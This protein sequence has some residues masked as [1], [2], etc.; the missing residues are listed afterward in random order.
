MIKK[1]QLGHRFA[2]FT[3]KSGE[4]TLTDLDT[5]QR[6]DIPLLQIWGD[7]DGVFVLSEGANYTFKKSKSGHC[8]IL[9]RIVLIKTEKERHSGLYL[10]GAEIYKLEG[11]E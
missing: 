6:Y 2:C 1:E 5:G 11:G 9:D 4:I 3:G 7:A 10:P 8:Y